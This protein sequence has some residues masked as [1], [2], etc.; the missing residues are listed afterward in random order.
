MGK[1]EI[2]PYNESKEPLFHVA[3]SLRQYWES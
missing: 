3:V 2:L 1:W